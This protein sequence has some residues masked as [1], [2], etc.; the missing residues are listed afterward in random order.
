MHDLIYIVRL[1]WREERRTFLR[2]LSLSL[3]VL[4]AGLALIGLSGW[5]I[6]A[7][8]VA[9]LAGAGAAFN[10]FTPGAGVRFLALGRTLARYGERLSTHDATLRALESLRITLLKGI[11]RKPF[12]AIMQ[13]RAS[14]TLNRILSDIDALDGLT[15]RLLFPVAAG[16]GALLAAVIV[17]ALLVSP[18]VSVWIL[19]ATLLPALAAGTFLVR[20]S[21]KPSAEIAELL[22]ESRTAVIEH[23]RG[24]V[25]LAFA[26]SIAHHRAPILRQFAQLE[27][28]AHRLA[29]AEYRAAMLLSLAV[30][31][32]AT[33][34]LVLAVLLV[35][36]DSLSVPLA[37]M[38]FFTALAIGEIL[39]PFQRGL[40]EV[41]K[42]RDAASR[43]VPDLT[44]DPPSTLSVATKDNIAPTASCADEQT[45]PVLKALDLTLKAPSGATLLSGFTLRLEAGETVAL[46]GRSGRGKSLLLDTF[47]RLRAPTDGGIEFLG[48][49]FRD[50]CEADFRQGVGYLTQR[51]AL[52]AGTVRETLLMAC[53]MA[54]DQRLRDVLD[55]VCLGDAFARRDGLDTMLVEA[56]GNLSGGEARRLVLASVLLRDPCLLLLDEPTEGL[57]E[58]TATA[59][60]EGCRKWVPHAAILIASHREAERRFAGRCIAL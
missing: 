30:T 18:I 22:R 56:G 16:F 5:F 52:I 54:T 23:L 38:A 55:A 8:A 15:L 49:D 36:R 34:V 1:L 25:L 41:G 24:R 6:T 32:A 28:L 29:K 21:L 13:M 48:L 47:A 33:G 42:M 40:A 45:G 12:A 14:A 39:M 3:A 9:G 43:I 58:A 2:G 37:A 4:L 7:A 19:A 53:P 31:L 50:Y 57:D 60:L 20:T 59:V 17:I 51:P 11:A 35:Q 46:T 27:T 26:G 44:G 10:V